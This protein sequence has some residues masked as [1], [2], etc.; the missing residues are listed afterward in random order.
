MKKFVK[1]VVTV[2]KSHADKVREA[3]GQAGA[4]HLGKYSFCSF[5]ITGTG[6]FLSEPGAQPAS[7]K[8]GKL[9]RVL[10]E[11]IEVT[12][13]KKALKKIIAVIKK[14][15][16]YKELAIDVYPLLYPN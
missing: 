13:Y 15:H 2:P 8:V 5:T 6:R 9:E 7:G 4:G 3:L 16:P 10:E 1:L 12:Y 11:R 14:V